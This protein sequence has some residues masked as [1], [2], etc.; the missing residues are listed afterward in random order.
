MKASQLLVCVLVDRWPLILPLW[1]PKVPLDVRLNTN[2]HNAEALCY[3]NI[4][5]RYQLCLLIIAKMVRLVF[6][7][8]PPR[9]PWRRL[10][11]VICLRPAVPQGT[12]WKSL[13]KIASVPPVLLPAHCML[14]L[15]QLPGDLEDCSENGTRATVSFDPDPSFWGLKLACFSA[16]V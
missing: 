6:E 14:T 16:L 8:Q 13:L 2:L 9:L 10:G 11:S 15:I 3:R 5:L 12:H 1:Q 7:N 4:T